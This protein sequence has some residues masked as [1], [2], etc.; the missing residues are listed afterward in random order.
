[1]ILFRNGRTFLHM[2]GRVWAD[3]TSQ[4]TFKEWVSG[5]DIVWR[6]GQIETGFAL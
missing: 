4:V 1:M 6:Y 3:R 5:G 2:H